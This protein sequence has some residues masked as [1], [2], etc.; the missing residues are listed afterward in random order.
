M[1]NAINSKRSGNSG[2]SYARRPS[3]S[4]WKNVRVGLGGLIRY[5]WIMML[6]LRCLRNGYGE[7]EESLIPIS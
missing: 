5:T 7:R 6:T 1:L 2:G 3:E 4:L